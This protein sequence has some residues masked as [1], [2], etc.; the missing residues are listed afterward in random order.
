MGAGP[1]WALTGEMVVGAVSSSAS[2]DV[3][4]ALPPG[5]APVPGPSVVVAAR[6]ATS[7]VG[8]YLELAVAQPARAGARVGMCVTTMAVDSR[9]S[10]D[11]GREKWGFPKELGALHWSE[12]GDERSLRW[13]ERGL[14][15]RWRVQGPAVPAWLPV[16]AVQQRSDGPVLVPGRLRGPVG[17][18]RVEVVAPAD[19]PL[20]ALAGRHPAAHQSRAHLRMGEGRPVGGAAPA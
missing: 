16:L 14:V 11:A 17:V 13:D 19:D 4:S 2:A 7:P 10:R 9:A 18:G 20:A 8:P 3:R 6:Y 5:F 12:D 15:V 1:G